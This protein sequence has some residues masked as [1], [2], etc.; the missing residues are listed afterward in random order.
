M[1]PAEPRQQP[2][3]GRPGRSIQQ[4]GGDGAMQIGEVLGDLNI[5]HHYESAP[6][7]EVSLNLDAYREHQRSQLAI[8][9]QQY[10]R[11]D[12]DPAVAL[13]GQDLRPVPDSR[14]AL[15]EAFIHHK[16]L[17]VVGGA[18]AGK[19]TS[20]RYLVASVLLGGSLAERLADFIPVYIELGRFR[21]DGSAP[22]LDSLLLLIAETLSLGKPCPSQPALRRV[23]QLLTAHRFLF[24]L[25]GLNE[26]RVELRSSCVTAANDLA[27]LY[28]E[29]R[30]VLSSRPHG[31]SPPQDWDVVLLRELED[32]QISELVARYTQ[33]A[34]S[35][36][37]LQTVLA[38]HN[39]LLRVPLF[40]DLVVRMSRSPLPDLQRRLRSRSGLVHHYVEYLLQRDLSF[41]AEI[42]SLDRLRDALDRL[43]QAF[44]T[45]GQVLPLAEARRAVEAEASGDPDEARQILDDL[46]RRG[47]LTTDGRTLRFW[48]QTLQEYF[49]AGSIVRRWRG[50]KKQIGWMPWWLRRLVAKPEE[51][52]ALDFM[53]A[54]LRDEEAEA[55]L[56]QALRVNPAL[57]ISWADDLSL[58]GRATQAMELF[59][60]TIG[61]F[62]LTGR[63]YK[64]LGKNRESIVE[65]LIGLSIPLMI[66]G[67]VLVTWLSGELSRALGMTLPD[68]DAVLYLCLIAGI[69]VGLSP[70]LDA[71][72]RGLSA[73]KLESVLG[74]IPEIRDPPLRKA[75]GSL[76]GEISR[77]SM[78]QRDIQALAQ[79]VSRMEAVNVDE[80]IK[81]LRG[82]EA[83]YATVRLI[84]RLDSPLARP[85]LKEL[86][87]L[88]NFRSRAAL[89]ALALRANRLRDERQ[90]IKDLFLAVWR[91]DALDF[92]IRRIA[93]KL[94]MH[95]GEIPGGRRFIFQYHTLRILKIVIIGIGLVLTEVGLV[96][97]AHSLFKGSD[98]F[99][100]FLV[101]LL[102]LTA[103]IWWDARRIGVREIGGLSMVDGSASPWNWAALCFSSGS[104]LVP[105]YVLTRPLIRRNAAP[106]DWDAL[107]QALELETTRSPHG[108]SLS[109]TQP[110]SVPSP[111]R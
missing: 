20:M 17:V 50:S 66:V 78:T 1:T 101:L 43:A 85:L 87:R 63:R 33:D 74:A 81:S 47:L 92:Q 48:H 34:A 88:N 73:E 18:G 22:P 61:R 25:D 97:A 79:S 16:R 77:S 86:L 24:L 70:L 31:F 93:R 27:K 91:N 95:A 42:L 30:I 82:S 2:E 40:L 19:S 56:R 96:A 11:L 6:D 69:L 62:T 26:A 35:Q 29:H 12:V 110:P 71:L 9:E 67:I 55:A 60:A 53:A 54:H 98:P 58:E 52:E 89:E 8:W 80:L 57:A 100:L 39:P 103:L 108:D 36:P 44:Q 10:T 4:T 51:E 102:G 107:L 5:H 90:E 21:G 106:V 49:Y 37:L 64:W 83:S 76:A 13:A 94:L 109:I 15:T 28:P 38:A 65:N 41:P 45:S 46:C 3:E 99:N 105:V 7:S 32:A 111:R 59:P 104:L 72:P 23:H 75:L 68:S 84:G 14:L